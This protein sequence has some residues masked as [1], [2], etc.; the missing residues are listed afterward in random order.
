MTDIRTALEAVGRESSHFDEDA[1]DLDPVCEGIA[2]FVADN[3]SFSSMG[4]IA[5]DRLLGRDTASSGAVEELTVGGGVEFTGS[6]GIQR[7]ALTGDVTASAGSGSTT[8]ANNAVSL[9]KMATMATASLLGRN[10]GGTGNVEV[11][12]AATARTLLN[13][14]ALNAANTWSAHQTVTQSVLT[15]GATI[16]VDL[17]VSDNFL[18]TIA[19]TGRAL[20]FTNGVAGKKFI[21]VVRQ[22]S[23]GGKTITNWD[24]I[25]WTAGV[26]PTLSTGAN[27]YDV[28]SCYCIT[29]S[30]I[31]ASIV[32]DFT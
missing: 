5:S 12:S 19:A 27:K 26:V 30:K 11:L 21:L 9:A 14:G 20:N 1:T 22:D 24:D 13:V 8:I 23:G 31:A 16:T 4:A 10:T 25:V 2:G 28:I 18:V 7:S 6:G 15:D 32:K 3:L 17:A 29:A